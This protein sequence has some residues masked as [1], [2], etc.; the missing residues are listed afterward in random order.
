MWPDSNIAVVTGAKSGFWVLDVDDEDALNDL[1]RQHGPLPATVTV[2]TGRGGRH[3]LFVCRSAVPTRVG[4]VVGEE[5]VRIDVKG[6]G[7]YAIAAPSAHITG[8]TYTWDIG[9]GP[10]DIGLAE[11][12]GWLLALVTAREARR[13]RRDGTAL[14]IALGARN[15]MLMR[16]GGALRRYGVG[17]AALGECLQAI[18]R[19]H[20][21][22]PLTET[23]VRAIARS[24]ARYTPGLS[25]PFQPFRPGGACTD[26]FIAR[27]LGMW[28]GDEVSADH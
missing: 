17:E 20:A 14:V 23:E 13:L 18:N 22:P 16:F 11:A 10:D 3:L 25:T 9:F 1:E 12:P 8:R 28:V 27:S 5:A 21:Q 26:E 15:D 4:L 2:R 24:V 19:H 7:G 6:D